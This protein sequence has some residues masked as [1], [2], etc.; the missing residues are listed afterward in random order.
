MWTFDGSLLPKKVGHSVLWEE[1]SKNWSL[2]INSNKKEAEMSSTIQKWTEYIK[3][4]DGS[5][6]DFA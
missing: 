2:V 3:W 6:L 4:H 5:D 1:R